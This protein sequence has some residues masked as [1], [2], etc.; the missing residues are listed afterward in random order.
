MIVLVGIEC[1]RDAS[2]LLSSRPARHSQRREAVRRRSAPHV[3]RA[4]GRRLAR[5]RRR[6]GHRA[7]Q[8]DRPRDPRRRPREPRVHRT[9]DRRLRRVSRVGRTVHARVRAKRSTGVPAQLIREL[10]HAYAARRA[11]GALL[12]ARHHRTS[13]RRRQRPRAHQSRAA[14]RPRRP[15]RLGRQSAART[16]QR[17]GRRRH[18]RDSEQVSRRPG[19]RRSTRAS[20]KFETRLERHAAAQ[21]RLEPHRHVRGDRARRARHALRHRRES[22]AVRGRSG[23]RDGAA[24]QPEAPDRARHLLDEDRRAGRRRLSRLGE[25][26]RV[27]RHGDQQRAARA[28]LPQGARSAR[29]GA[30]RH[31][32][33]VRARAAAWATIGRS[34]RR[35][36]PGTSAA[37]S[38]PGT[39]A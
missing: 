6:I 22:G 38:R 28:A 21:A 30:R 31:R 11:R 37:R 19:R 24:A 34:T 39:P 15:L 14:L 8:R 36:R 2:D 1:A 35:S 29:R 23:A 4:L 18:G 25:L 17:A 27:R 20:R 9:R 13:Q 32:D 3:E 26:V 33:H 16:E 10:A 7:R 12:D 5:P